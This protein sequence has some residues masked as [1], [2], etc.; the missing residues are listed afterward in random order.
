M[1]SKPNTEVIITV[2]KTKRGKG[3][4]FLVQCESNEW[5]CSLFSF[6]FKK[7]ICL[8]SFGKTIFCHLTCLS[9]FSVKFN[10]HV[11]D[12]HPSDWEFYKPDRHFSAVPHSLT[13]ETPITPPPR[14]SWEIPGISRWQLLRPSP[15]SAY[16]NVSEREQNSTAFVLTKVKQS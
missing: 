12:S 16:K 5:L 1:V 10:S 6:L 13:S 15:D 11:S 8:F 7:F 2:D 4:M 9:L 14:T 3:E